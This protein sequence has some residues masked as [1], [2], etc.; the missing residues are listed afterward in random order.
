LLVVCTSLN[1]RTTNIKYYFFAF[2]DF[3]WLY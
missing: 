3:F 1:I 2:E